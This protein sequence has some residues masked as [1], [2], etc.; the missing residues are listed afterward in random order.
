MKQTVSFAYLNAPDVCAVQRLAPVTC[1]KRPKL[2]SVHALPYSPVEI[3]LPQP[4]ITDNVLRVPF[5]PG[6]TLATVDNV[7]AVKITRGVG[8]AVDPAS[9]RPAVLGRVPGDR[10]E[11]RKRPQAVPLRMTPP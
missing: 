4:L 1:R 7:V 11:R 3:A 5:I 10:G 9:D 6:I 8:E 2:L